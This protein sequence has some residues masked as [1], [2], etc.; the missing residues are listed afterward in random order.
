MRS[1]Y[2]FGYFKICSS[3]K[4]TYGNPE[5]TQGIISWKCIWERHLKF[6]MENISMGNHQK[7][8]ISVNFWQSFEEKIYVLFTAV[9][10]DRFLTKHLI[11]HDGFSMDFI[12]F[13]ELFDKFQ[14]PEDFFCYIGN[15]SKI[16]QIYLQI[17]FSSPFI[18]LSKQSTKIMFSPIF[19]FVRINLIWI[20]IKTYLQMNMHKVLANSLH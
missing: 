20:W 4:E 19:F 5:K 11:C 16:T 13:I 8:L 2:L 3:L 9:I 18:H 12:I 14:I 15:L 7:K 6:L 1:S 10:S 17:L